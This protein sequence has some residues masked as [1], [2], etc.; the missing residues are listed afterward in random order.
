[1]RHSFTEATIKAHQDALGA[2][3]AMPRLTWMML[4]IV[5]LAAV[6]DFAL[7]M[8]IPR[9]SLLGRELGG[10]LYCL[11]VTPYLIAVHRFVIVGEV[12]RRYRLDWRDQR[13]QLFFG[14]WFAIFL[15]TKAMAL[16]NLA[17]RAVVISLLAIAML[18][19]I[20]VVTTRCIILFPAIAIDAPGATPRNAFDDTHGHGWY[21]F[22]LL[23]FVMLPSALAMAV[24]VGLILLIRPAAVLVVM[25]PLFGFGTILW[26]TLGVA[27]AS[28]LY[29]NLGDRL[30]R[31]V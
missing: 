16:A 31:P 2:F 10:I 27:V 24:V 4:G 30:N 22:F 21:I 14:W 25:A 13:F 17:P 18:I 19:A 29:R 9:N 11:L 20:F 7:H 3:Q 5:V 8:L 15:L 28:Q 23:I 6:V 12:T 1:V 26:L